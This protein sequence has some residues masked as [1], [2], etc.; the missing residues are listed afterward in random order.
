MEPARR[1]ERALLAL[2]LL[3]GA[4][5]RLWLLLGP[6]SE[7]D[8]DE[9][10]VGLM[11]LQMPGELPAFYWQQEYLGTLEPL[12]AWAVFS[13]VG[14]SSSA[15]KG[16]PAL[17]SLFFVALVYVVARPAFGAAPALLAASY[18]AVPPSFFAAWSGMENGL[19]LLLMII[20]SEFGIPIPGMKSYACCR[21]AI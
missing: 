19:S 17:Y 18:L 5:L 1:T 9:A 2:I 16:V 7:I 13:V 10:V 14:P 15:L 12:S 20:A 4:A 8:A 21:M 6:F 3:L 11:A